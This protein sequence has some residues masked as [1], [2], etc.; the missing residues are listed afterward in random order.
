M[1]IAYRDSGSGFF[2][3]VRTQTIQRLTRTKETTQSST[4]PKQNIIITSTP[5]CRSALPRLRFVAYTPLPA[6]TSPG[7]PAAGVSWDCHLHINTSLFSLLALPVIA[8]IGWMVRTGKPV[9]TASTH[10]FRAKEDK[11]SMKKKFLAFQNTIKM[12]PWNKNTAGG[13]LLLVAAQSQNY[14]YEYN[15]AAYKAGDIAASIAPVR[16]VGCNR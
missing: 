2:R 6:I 8:G 3:P 9:G 5:R 16:D 14:T 10:E 12:I 13:E 4:A 7:C 15:T 11:E 1:T